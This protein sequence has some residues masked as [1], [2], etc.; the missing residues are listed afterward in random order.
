M[1]NALEYDS[2]TATFRAPFRRPLCGN[3]LAYLAFIG[4]QHSDSSFH[5]LYIEHANGGIIP[6][7]FYLNI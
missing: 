7:N 4:N 2:M 6:K 5:H 1:D 3:M